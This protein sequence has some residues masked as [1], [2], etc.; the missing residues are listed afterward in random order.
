MAFGLARRFEAELEVLHPCPPPS[1]RLPYATELSPIYFEAYLDVSRKQVAYEEKEAIAWFEKASANWGEVES[2]LLTVEAWS[3]P[4]WPNGP[5]PR[6][7][8]C[9]PSPRRTTRCSTKARDAA[10]FSSGRPVLFVPDEAS[11]HVGETVVIAWKDSV[12]S[13]RA[14]AAAG[15]F[16]D[17]ARRVRLISLIEEG[18]P[19]DETAVAMANYLTAACLPV[20][21]KSVELGDR[22]VGDAILEEAGSGVLLVMGGY[23]RWRWHEWIFGGATDHVLRH[24]DVAVLMSH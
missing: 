23:G 3:G 13:A 21:L 17:G 2:Q 6:I 14:V 4:P 8:C 9:R 7:A 11:G 5:R 22:E 24:T 16:L 15:P 1:Q 20:E 18:E 10:L 12:E 19:E